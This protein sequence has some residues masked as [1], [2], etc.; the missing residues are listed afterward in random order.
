MFSKL[1][2]FMVRDGAEEC[3]FTVA[4]Q[5]ESHF[6]EYLVKKSGLQR[7]VELASGNRRHFLKAGLSQRG[8]RG[9]AGPRPCYGLFLSLPEA[10]Q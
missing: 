5:Q 4:R 6:T 9:G 8:P 7:K 2:S 3:S 10:V 1:S